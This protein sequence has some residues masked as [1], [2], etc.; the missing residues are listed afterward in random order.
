MNLQIISLSYILDQK[1]LDN[2]HINF[3]NNEVNFRIEAEWGDH[4]YQH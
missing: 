3:L 1:L 2:N 4:S